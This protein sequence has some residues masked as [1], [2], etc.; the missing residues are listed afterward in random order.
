MDYPRFF[1]LNQKEESISIQKG[2][3]QTILL[4]VMAKAVYLGSLYSQVYI[5]KKLQHKIVIIFS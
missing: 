4:P 2:E 1:V 5:S 3:G